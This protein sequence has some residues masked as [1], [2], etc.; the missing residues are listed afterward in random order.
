MGLFVSVLRLPPHV[1]A[2]L[3]LLLCLVGAYSL[4]NSLLDLWVLTATGVIGYGLRKLSVDPAPLVVAL[5]LGPIM[6][7]SLR[8]TLFMARGDWTDMFTRPLSVALLV[9]G[10]ARRTLGARPAAPEV[11]R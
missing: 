2:T 5:V 1:L 11:P 8:Q 9:I 4:N 6:E 7:K 3:V 10:L